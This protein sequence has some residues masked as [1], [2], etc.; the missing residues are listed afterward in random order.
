MQKS[1]TLK[2]LTLKYLELNIPRAK[3]VIR[4][5][6]LVKLIS[7]IHFAANSNLSSDIIPLQESR[8]TL[9]I[10]TGKSGGAWAVIR[11]IVSKE[12]MRSLMDLWLAA[13]TNIKAKEN[14]IEEARLAKARHSVRLSEH[15]PALYTLHQ[16][17]T[18]NDRF[19][20]VGS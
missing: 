16:L 20:T 3:P 1:S 11:Q 14:R 13:N 8:K 10:L 18:C 4:F 5:K 2:Y 17:E 6:V 12:G 15:L 9:K 19:V 7:T